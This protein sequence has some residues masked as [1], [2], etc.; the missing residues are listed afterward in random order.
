M[1]GLHDGDAIA[2]NSF[3]GWYFCGFGSGVNLNSGNDTDFRD[4]TGG[5][6]GS[7]LDECGF[8]VA[9]ADDVIR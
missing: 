7:V 3:G 6:V 9:D 8:H 5:D 1:G 4:E 2:R